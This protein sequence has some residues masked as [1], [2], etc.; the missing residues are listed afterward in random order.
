[1]RVH[2]LFAL[3]PVLACTPA[4]RQTASTVLGV[5]APLACNLVA[6]FSGEAFAGTLC[7]DIAGTVRRALEAVPVASSPAAVVPVAGTAAPARG[8]REGLVPLGLPGRDS[9]EVVCG[10]YRAQV[11]RAL[12]VGHAR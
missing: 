9:R 4:D 10:E 5:G 3:L 8:C 6:V 12:D 1:M 11:L 2:F 7:D